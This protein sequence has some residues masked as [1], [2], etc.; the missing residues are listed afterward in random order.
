M[1]YPLPND[2]E[3]H[4]R[5]KDIQLVFRAVLG[6]NILAPIPA[7]P[8]RII[9]VGTGG[10]AW[11]VEVANAYPETLVLGLDISPITSAEAP[12]NCKFYQGDLNEGLRFDND[13]MDLVHSR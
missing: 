6:G 11:V 9:D 4:K 7:K 5:L 1:D 13:C 12:R 3:E 10:G 8:T 2:E